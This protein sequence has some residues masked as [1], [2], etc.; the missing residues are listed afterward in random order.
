MTGGSTAHDFVVGVGLASSCIT[1]GGARNT[2][3]IVKNGLYAPEAPSGENSALSLLFRFALIRH[4]IRQG[5]RA[6]RK[7][8]NR[9][10]EAAPQNDPADPSCW[11]CHQTLRIPTYH[12]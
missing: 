11:I 8:H 3:H 5:G 6:K 4:R 12:F 9:A 2:F 7:G 1:C 10:D